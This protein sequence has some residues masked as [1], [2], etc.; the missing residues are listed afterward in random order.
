MLLHECRHTRD[1]GIHTRASGAAT[2]SVEVVAH[3]RICF[4]IG[5]APHNKANRDD[6]AAVKGIQ[7]LL[8]VVYFPRPLL[9]NARKNVKKNEVL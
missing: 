2:K 9:R 4:P 6:R 8:P 5:K 3:L 7:Q 1:L